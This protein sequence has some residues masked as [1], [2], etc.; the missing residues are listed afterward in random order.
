MASQLEVRCPTQ[1]H[2]G[3]FK[4]ALHYACNESVFM[5]YCVLK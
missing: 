1:E 5:L 2:H 3:V 4:D